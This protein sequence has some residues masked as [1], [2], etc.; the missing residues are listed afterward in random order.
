M[1]Q[2][3]Y[4][5]LGK[6]APSRVL[7]ASP[8]GDAETQARERKTRLDTCPQWKKGGDTCRAAQTKGAKGRKGVTGEETASTLLL[9]YK[10]NLLLEERDTVAAI[11][12]GPRPGCHTVSPSRLRSDGTPS[13]KFSQ[14]GL[15]SAW[16]KR[17]A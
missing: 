3:S 11:I 16:I 9:V 5:S 15:S 1:F 2:T 17:P 4:E 6:T 13:R 14:H 7:P 12:T 8:L 10:V